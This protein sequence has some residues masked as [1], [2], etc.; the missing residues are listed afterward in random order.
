[1]G[2][3]EFL[4]EKVRDLK[5]ITMNNDLTTNPVDFRYHDVPICTENRIR[6]CGYGD[7]IPYMHVDIKIAKSPERTYI[8]VVIMGSRNIKMDY[9][10]ER[11]ITSD[12]LRDAVQF[13][14]QCL[15]D[16]VVVIYESAPQMERLF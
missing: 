12:I 9:N 16:N 4:E 8:T 11:V 2:S 10:V 5:F 7:D 1:M 6:I 14:M 15:D 13:A 3:K